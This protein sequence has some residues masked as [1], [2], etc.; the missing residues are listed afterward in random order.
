MTSAG[1]PVPS[2]GQRSRAL[3]FA[4]N[5]SRAVRT[6][7]NAPLRAASTAIA[8]IRCCQIRMVGAAS[9][10]ST[11]SNAFSVAGRRYGTQRLS[12]MPYRAVRSSSSS[13]RWRAGRLR[14]SR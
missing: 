4:G 12:E 13:L 6:S 14:L 7:R 1:S 11:R 8:E 2:P 9:T 3:P 10:S 5:S